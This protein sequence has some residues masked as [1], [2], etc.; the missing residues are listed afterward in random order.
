MVIK[1]RFQ[2]MKKY[3]FCLLFIALLATSFVNGQSKQITG[4]VRDKDGSLPAVS[5]VE[6]GTSNG[7]L[8]DENGRFKLTLRGTSNIIVVSYVGYIRREIKIGSQA[9]L[10]IVLAVDD[11]LL[12]EV[13]VVGY[14]TQKK[15]TV[16]GSIASV[17]NSEIVTTKNE[18]VLNML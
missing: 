15:A 4:V 6:K 8:T 12:G 14:G 3:L 2:N 11:N 18:N 9:D 17:T 13:V 7:T 16:T 1:L 10:Q 5:I